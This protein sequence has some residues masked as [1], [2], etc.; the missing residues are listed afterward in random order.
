MLSVGLNVTRIPPAP[1]LYLRPTAG[2]HQ[3]RFATA[4]IFQR[5]TTEYSISISAG[6]RAKA[7]SRKGLRR[8]VTPAVGWACQCPKIPWERGYLACTRAGEPPA[9]PC[10]LTETDDFDMTLGGVR[11]LSGESS[12][13]GVYGSKG[14]K[15]AI[16]GTQDSREDT[17][18]Q[19]N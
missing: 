6:P 19:E 1:A 15:S 4:H 8:M 12:D 13:V 18:H 2:T 7:Q 10:F 11:A 17:F 9:L 16:I 3:G 14:M 5:N